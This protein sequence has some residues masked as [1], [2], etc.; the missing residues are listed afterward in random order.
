MKTLW[1]NLPF[2]PA[3]S[4][5]PLSFLSNVYRLVRFRCRTVTD[6]KYDYV[7]KAFR[8]AHIVCDELK[9]FY[10][11]PCRVPPTVRLPG[12]DVN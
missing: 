7:L 5:R 12:D 2:T 4:V 6:V 8:D 10:T 9:R 11:Q 3:P 1:R